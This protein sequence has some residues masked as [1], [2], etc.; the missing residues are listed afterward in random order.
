MSITKLETKEMYNVLFAHYDLGMIK[1][2]IERFSEKPNK[3]NKVEKCDAI[4]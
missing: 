4:N 1:K 3:K 2:I